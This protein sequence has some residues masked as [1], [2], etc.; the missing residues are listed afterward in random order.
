MKLDEQFS[1]ARKT[2]WGTPLGSAPT[3]CA[4]EGAAARL[5]RAALPQSAF[6]LIELLVVIAIMG[7]LA[8]LV[9]GLS[10]VSSRKLRESRVKT[11]LAAL[12]SAIENYKAAVGFY[13]PDN[14]NNASLPP[15]YYELT[16]CIFTNNPSRFLTLGSYEEITAETYKRV[17]KLSGVQNSARDPLDVK[18]TRFTPKATQYAEINDPD[19]IEILVVPF[20]GPP[21]RMIAGKRQGDTRGPVMLNPWRYDASSPNRHNRQTYDLWAEVIIGGRTTIIGN[22]KD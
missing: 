17:F 5:K 11:E 7:G 14:T 6:T 18:F 15:L 1:G 22:W 2:G 13:P 4:Q 21:T 3:G 10:S 8:A 16:G 19:D 12:V 9:V 20:P